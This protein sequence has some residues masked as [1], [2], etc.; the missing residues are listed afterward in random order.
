MTIV[1]L[2][3]CLCFLFIGSVFVSKD[4]RD[5]VSPYVDLSNVGYIQLCPITIDGV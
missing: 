4:A 2:L 1:L 5:L 3:V